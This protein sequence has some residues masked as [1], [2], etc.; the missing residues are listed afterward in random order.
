MS[1]ARFGPHS[2]VYV[3]GSV[4]GGVVCCGCMLGYHGDEATFHGPNGVM[5]HLAEHERAGHVVPP[6][7]IANMMA[8]DARG[9][10]EWC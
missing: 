9:W 5:D 6:D 2:D 1:F 7:T 3:Y 8:D 4:H 10:I